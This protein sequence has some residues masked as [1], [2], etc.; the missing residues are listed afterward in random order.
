MIA[1]FDKALSN[2]VLAM[3]DMADTVCPGGNFVNTV[4]SVYDESGA[5]W[6]YAKAEGGQ[7]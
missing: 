5:R 1:Y 3:D 7:D 2:S 4:G 6:L